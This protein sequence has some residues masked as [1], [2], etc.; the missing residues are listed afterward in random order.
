MRLVAR[1]GVEQAVADLFTDTLIGALRQYP[2]A[3]ALSDADLAS[4]ITLDERNQL[5][6]SDDDSCFAQVGGAAGVDRIV[7]GSIGRVGQSLVM[8]LTAVDPAEARVVA[9]VTERADDEA[10]L[11]VLPSMVDR[12]VRERH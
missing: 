10:L 8:T 9:S 4:M 3:S 5:L 11:D 12:L 7:H 1:T 2:G 6:G